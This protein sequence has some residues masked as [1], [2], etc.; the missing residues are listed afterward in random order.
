MILCESLQ[1]FSPS[2]DHMIIAGA[3]S[4][5]GS[6]QAST[7][8][9]SSHSA[10]VAAALPMSGLQLHFLD[11]SG[12]SWTWLQASSWPHDHG[13]A[14]GHCHVLHVLFVQGHVH[15][16]VHDE[17]DHHLLQVDLGPRQ[18]PWPWPAWLVRSAVAH[19]PS[20]W[21]VAQLPPQQLCSQMAVLVPEPLAQ[22]QAHAQEL[23]QQLSAD[24]HAGHLPARR[25]PSSMRSLPAAT[26]D[27]SCCWLHCSWPEASCLCGCHARGRQYLP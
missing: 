12:C 21:P 13:H 25:M 17:E 18:L 11:E 5:S 1:V 24:L 15:G 4:S 22:V 7:D 19:S 16:H 10:G 23:A 3:S 20:H 27:R 26:S 9:L 8:T 6:I 14:R 2:L